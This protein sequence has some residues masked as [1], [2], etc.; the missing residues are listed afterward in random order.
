MTPITY[1]GPHKPP[2]SVHLPGRDIVWSGDPIDVDDD[3]AQALLAT[4]EWV[5]DS[6]PDTVAE[7]KEWVGDD[8]ERAAQALATEQARPEPRSTLINHL[9]ALTQED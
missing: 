9:T 5:G 6:A 3:T 2:V 1:T 8:P 7:I 4:G